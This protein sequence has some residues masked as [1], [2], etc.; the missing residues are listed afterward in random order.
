MTL[1]TILELIKGLFDFPQQVLALVRVMRATP[2][3]NREKIIAA[4][5]KE[6]D[7]FAN[8]GRPDW[9]AS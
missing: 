9:D 6:A 4:M 2:E 3:E 1:V 7:S 5:Q 8:T